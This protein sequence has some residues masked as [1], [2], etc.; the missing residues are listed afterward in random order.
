MPVL[1]TQVELKHGRVA[2][3]GA[4]GVIVQSFWQVCDDIKKDSSSYRILVR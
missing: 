1:S 3:L 4:L 2:M